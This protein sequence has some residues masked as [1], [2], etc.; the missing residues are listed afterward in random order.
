MYYKEFNKVS[1]DYG[2]KLFTLTRWILSPL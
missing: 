1:S 2:K